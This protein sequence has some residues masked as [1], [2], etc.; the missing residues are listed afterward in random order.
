MKNPPM[1]ITTNSTA[2]HR[3]TAPTM[4]A[5]IAC[6][7]QA[8]QATSA[9]RDVRPTSTPASSPSALENSSAAVPLATTGVVP[10]APLE[11]DHHVVVQAGIA[12]RQQAE[13]RGVR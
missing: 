3:S 7:C 10:A 11:R 9:W 2:G 4:A 6:R 1:P 12:D 13:E 5:A 8:V